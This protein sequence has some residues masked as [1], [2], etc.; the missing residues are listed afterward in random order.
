MRRLCFL[1]WVLSQYRRANGGAAAAEFA[2]IL[3]L[4]VIPVLNA[5]DLAVYAWNRMQVD[6]AA[7]V[8]V[9]AAWATCDSSANL[10]ATPNAYANCPGMPLA[11][12][13]AVQSTPLGANVTV[14]STTEG[15][16]CINSASAL[17]AVGTFPGTKPADC[18][19]VGSASDKPGDYV[20]IAASYAYAPVFP[21]VSIVSL[22]TTPIVRTA[23]M[24]LG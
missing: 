20:V 9:Q 10:P 1:Q 13:T 23:W 6:N 22:L 18:S 19:S 14:T 8:A 24:R 16:Y 5:V 4:L 11:V 3:G 2:L 12:V 15:Y 17:V 21:S 7:Q